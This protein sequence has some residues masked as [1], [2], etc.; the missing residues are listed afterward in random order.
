MRVLHWCMLGV[1][2]L[3]LVC[4]VT[5]SQLCKSLIT[6]VDGFHTIFVLLR[7][8]LPPPPTASMSKPPLSSV[9]SS[10][11]PPHASSSSAALPTTL[12][13]ESSTKPLPGSQAGGFLDC[14]VSF[15][16]S[17]IRPV[18]TFI[19]ALFLT[20]M[21]L[22]YFLEI[23]SFCLD[24]HPV[25]RPLLLVVVGGVSL[26]HKMLVVWM[27][28]D[29]LQDE[30]AGVRE[31]DSHLEVNHRVL[32][33]EETKGQPEPGRV[34]DDIN[35]VQSAMNDSL[36]NGALVLCNLGI[37]S[38]PDIDSHAASQQPEDHLHA[39]AAQ[40]SRDCGAGSAVADLKVHRCMGHLDN[41]NAFN[42]SPVCKSSL[43]IERTVPSSQWPVSLLSFVL[44][45]QGLCTAL[46]ALINSLVMLL[47][48]PRCLHSSGTCGL[49]VYLDPGLSLL[50]V[51]TLIASAAP[52]VHRYGLLLLQA[53]PPHICASDLER[54]ITCVPGVRAV[55]DLHI[56]QLTESFTVA[57]VHVHCHAGFPVHRCAD[58]M[59][60]VTKVLCSVGVSC[61]TIQPEFASCS[62]SSAGS[63]G[64]ASP[65]VH[66][67]DPSLPPLLYCS[68]ACGKACAGNMC[69]SSLEEETRTLQ[70]PA[71]GETKEEP[72]TLVIE[73]TFL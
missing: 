49:L 43:H 1:T 45:L 47:I 19:S 67:A 4:E 71:A 27:N 26:L 5:I 48:G 22:S 13:A 35:H 8:A 51:I 34:L 54:R 64:D 41:Q 31:T 60:G 17:R 44:V 11:S 57:S 7:M 72:Q 6:L 65:V 3:L 24:P 55:H 28:L 63:E 56:W 10:T 68:L 36:H 39:A 40:E 52:Q 70:A 15:T 16:G 33:A 25:Q 69:C 66:R 59:S 42:A 23:I 9:D 38:V 62:G 18:G 50:A 46:L 58:L 53:T 20:F 73:N 61:C 14:G 37:S 30:N 2:I 32:A 21:C 12:P 29:Q